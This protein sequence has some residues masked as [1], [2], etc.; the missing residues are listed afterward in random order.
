MAFFSR[1]LRLAEQAYY[2]FDR[3]LLAE[4][5]AITLPVLL[6]RSLLHALHESQA[7]DFC[8]FQSKQ[9]MVPRQQRHLTY[10]SEFTTD[11]RHIVGKSNTV[12]DALSRAGTPTISSPHPGVDYRSMAAAQRADEELRS[13]QPRLDS[14][15]ATLHSTTTT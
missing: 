7:V 12:A 6:R 2:E 10:V 15:F 1:K 4:Y 11:V 5:I 3:E 14:S 9:S 13:E 8:G